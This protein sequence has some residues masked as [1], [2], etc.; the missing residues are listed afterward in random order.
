[1]MKVWIFGLIGLSGV[2]CAAPYRPVDPS[3][4]LAHGLSPYRRSLATATPDVGAAI[5]EAR[6]LIAEGRRRADVRAFAY[7]EKRLA[8]FA[9]QFDSNDELA[10]LSADIHQYRHD[11][12]GAALILDRLIARQPQNSSARL[13]RAEIRLAQGRGSDALHDC[14]SLVGRESPW[15]W[16]ACSAQSYAI[17]GRLAAAKQLLATTLKGASIDGARGAWA[18]GIMAD[19]EAQSG[20][21]ADAEAWLQRA[22]AANRDDHVAA[23]E[24]IDYMI[25][26]GRNQ[27]ALDF[28]RDRP[29]SDAYLIRKAEA[30][31]TLDPAQSALV[32]GDLQRRFAE[33]DALGDR[34]HLRE[35]AM[36]ELRFGDARMALAH[37]RENFR[38]QRELIDAHLVLEA[39]ARVGDAAGAAEVMQWLRDTHTEDARL[40]PELKTLQAGA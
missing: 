12:T 2:C 18:A 8:P 34:T 38:T 14:L 27:Q 9:A 6:S 22:L 35:R 23:A 26:S 5:E 39:A 31:A 16:S 36:F 17:N 28:I 40:T 32:V 7:A 30:L 4:E 33:A 3:L 37:A 13:M 15:I 10:L 20:N 11:F 25:A 19:L 21:P 1:M 29:V 24:L